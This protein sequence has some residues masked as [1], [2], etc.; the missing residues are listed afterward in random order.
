MDMEQKRKSF[1]ERLLG[2]LQNSPWFLD[3]CERI[4]AEYKNLQNGEVYLQREAEKLSGLLFEYWQNSIIKFI[5]TNYLELPKVSG[6][7]SVFYEDK[8]TGKKEL[9]IKI[10]RHTTQKEIIKAFHIAKQLQQLMPK[11]LVRDIQDDMTILNLWNKYSQ[12]NPRPRSISNSIASE[13]N[14]SDGDVRKRLSEL[15]KILRLRDK[16]KPLGSAYRTCFATHYYPYH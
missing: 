15:K 5:K 6:T 16:K 1:D 3:E 11:Y 2:I 8:L 14:I 4:R 13:L 9:S 7:Y 10:Y 12:Q